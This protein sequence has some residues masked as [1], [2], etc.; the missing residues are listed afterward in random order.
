MIPNRVHKRLHLEGILK[1][2]LGAAVEFSLSPVLRWTGSGYP[3]IP[4]PED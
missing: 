1:R 4:G 3:P 2:P